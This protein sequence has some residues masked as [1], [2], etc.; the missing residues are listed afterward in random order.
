MREINAARLAEVVESRNEEAD[1]E[2]DC[3][4]ENDVENPPSYSQDRDV[5]YTTAMDEPSEL[6]DSISLGSD[7]VLSDDSCG[8]DAVGKDVPA[9]VSPEL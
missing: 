4:L 3:G 1:I 2:D 9:E 8:S 6:C 5:A 7:S